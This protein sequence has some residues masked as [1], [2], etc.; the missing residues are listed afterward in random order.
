MKQF[1]LSLYLLLAPLSASAYFL[2]VDL[3]EAG[4]LD[5][6]WSVTAGNPADVAIRA[7]IDAYGNSGFSHDTYLPPEGSGMLV[8]DGRDPLT[9]VSVDFAG[10]A[11]ENLNLQ[12]FFTTLD[13]S[14]YPPSLD[15]YARILLNGVEIWS[16]ASIDVGSGDGMDNTGWQ[17]LFSPI[18]AGMNNLRFQVQNSSGNPADASQLA[19]D[20][21]VIAG[22][23]I[24]PRPEGTGGNS[25][26]SPGTVALFGIG[27]LG[28][29]IARS[30]GAR[31]T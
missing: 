23:G 9:E 2:P 30:R 1:V 28:L 10:Y 29:G 26:P 3:F 8:L 27:L 12:W 4:A 16:I 13:S 6:K 31:A 5:P 15:D 22:S 19:F 18:L 11:G 14:R 17:P 24:D 20:A 7:S 25:V 21:I